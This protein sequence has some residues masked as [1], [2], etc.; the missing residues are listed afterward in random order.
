HLHAVFGA[1]GVLFVGGVNQ[2]VVAIHVVGRVRGLVSG[3]GEQRGNQRAKRVVVV[4]GR[5]AQQRLHGA[6]HADGGVEAAVNIG[7][8]AVAVRRIFADDERDAAMSVHM[9][10]AGLG[11]VLENEK[12]GVVP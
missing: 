1:G 2:I 10:G 7:C 6:D 9:I 8:A 11:V 5:Q 3:P 4:H 12:R